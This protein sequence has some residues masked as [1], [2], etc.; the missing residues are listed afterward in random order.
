MADRAIGDAVGRSGRVDALF[1]GRQP[2][3]PKPTAPALLALAVAI[4]LIRGGER[5]GLTGSA[6]PPRRGEAQILRLA[7]AVV[8]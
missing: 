6:L 1:L 7:E 4:L 5:V 8:R 3:R 2:A